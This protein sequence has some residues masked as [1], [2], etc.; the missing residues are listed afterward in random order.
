MSK[1]NQDISRFKR[2]R[3]RSKKTAFNH[4][5]L[6]RLCIFRS[7]KHIEA[8]IIDDRKSITLVS[9]STYEKEISGKL[10]KNSTKTEASK[11]VGN[12]I[13]E[14]ALKLDIKQ[15]VFDRNGN[16]YSGRIKALAD[17]ARE[18]GLKI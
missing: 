11:H 6:S 3:N 17:A 5:T 16:P 4:P 8:Q 12:A 15:V 18:G 7:N 10:K 1:L 13:A 2:R 14:R 9:A